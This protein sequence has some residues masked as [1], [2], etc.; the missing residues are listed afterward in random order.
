MHP[1][2]PGRRQKIFQG[3]DN[4]KKTEN[5]TVK[6]FS[7]WGRAT[8]KKTDKKPENSSIN[9]GVTRDLNQGSKLREGPTNLHSSMI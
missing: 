9:T 1:D 4:R 2:N 3:V 6:P 5:S 7:G 8:E